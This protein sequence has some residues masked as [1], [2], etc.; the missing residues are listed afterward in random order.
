MFQPGLHTERET[1]TGYIDAQLRGLR[2]AAYGLTDEQARQAPCR[3]GLSIGGIL[4]HTAYGMRGHVP[5]LRA[6][7]DGAFTPEEWAQA[8]AEFTDSFALR[9]DETLDGALQVF[10][11]TRRALIDYLDTVDLDQEV[12]EPPAPWYGREHSVAAKAR[13]GLTALLEELARHAGHADIIREEIDG[14]QAG[15]LY[16]AVAGLPGNQFMQPW[17]PAQEGDRREE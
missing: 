3:S 14:A 16:L 5:G 6:R 11:A 9:D 12:M 1:L 15:P 10:D 2:N 7:S 4:K 8:A 17:R 13:Y